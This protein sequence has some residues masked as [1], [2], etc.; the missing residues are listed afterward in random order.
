MFIPTLLLA[1]TA[2]L[3]KVVYLLVSAAYWYTG[4]TVGD[5]KWGIFKQDIDWRGW[6]DQFLWFV[7]N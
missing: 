4:V 7:S 1:Q 3:L 2:D 5:S 6:E